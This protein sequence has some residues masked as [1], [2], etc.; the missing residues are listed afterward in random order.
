MFFI[1]TV[2]MTKYRKKVV[3]G[4]CHK[5][6][7]AE[8]K[9]KKFGVHYFVGDTKCITKVNPRRVRICFSCRFN[10]SFFEKVILCGFIFL[11]LNIFSAK[12]TVP[13]PLAPV[14]EVR[15]K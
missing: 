15:T 4:L 2:A 14:V 9:L 5:K 12:K 8:Y 3:C 11:E 10:P 6:K 7:T 1:E 13:M